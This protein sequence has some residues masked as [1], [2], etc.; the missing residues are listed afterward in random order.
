MSGYE[1]V[2]PKFRHVLLES[3]AERLNFLKR[4]RWVDYDTA[5]SVLRYLEELLTMP[6]R[7]RMPNLLIVG[8]SDNGK[9]TLIKRF[10]RTHGEGRVADGSVA[11]RPIVLVQATPGT[12]Q[13][14]IYLAILGRFHAPHR[15]TDRTSLLRAQVVHLFQEHRVRMLIVDEFHSILNGPRVRQRECVDALKFL[16]NELNIPIVGVGTDAVLQVLTTDDQHVRRFDKA[17]LP[18]WRPDKRFQKLVAGYE[19][20]LPL[21]KPS[22]LGTPELAARLHAH[23]AGIL[24]E[25]V[26]LIERSAAEAITSGAER[27]DRAIIDHAAKPR[28]PE[29][30]FRQII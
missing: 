15:H 16:C 13:K 22:G 1:H 4:E 5:L 3:D 20:A 24:G 17:V 10:F 18:V 28:D 19:R 30:G 27:I 25:T 29:D 21:K 7:N 11:V 8:E 14:D 2:H 6:K 26:K 9:T 23:S 12:T